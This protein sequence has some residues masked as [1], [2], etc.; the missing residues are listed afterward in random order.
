MPERREFPE[1]GMRLIELDTD[2]I[3][4]ASPHEEWS[5]AGKVR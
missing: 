3:Q 5:G 2:L 1:Y 4:S